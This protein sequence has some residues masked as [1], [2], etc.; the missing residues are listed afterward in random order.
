MTMNVR[1]LGMQIAREQ[2]A[3]A[4]DAHGYTLPPALHEDLIGRIY[5]FICKVKALEFGAEYYR[6]LLG[7]VDQVLGGVGEANFANVPSK[8]M[9]MA[10]R[11]K[12]HEQVKAASKPAPAPATTYSTSD[13]EGHA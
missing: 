5:T 13:T 1:E 8:A 7:Q 9:E 3:S 6:G 12:A 4:C 11:L 2:I 10:A